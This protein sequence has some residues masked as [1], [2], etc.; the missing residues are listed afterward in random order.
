MCN[1]TPVVRNNYRIGLHNNGKLVE[2]FNTD[3]ELFGGS[4]VT[5]L[6]ELNIENLPYDGRDYSISLDLAP[7]AVMV[8]RFL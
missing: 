1:F 8:F 2:I 5:N 7:L 4:G 6:G 3:A